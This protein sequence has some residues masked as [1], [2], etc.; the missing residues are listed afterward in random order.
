M[1][2]IVL[3]KHEFLPGFASLFA[4]LIST[5]GVEAVAGI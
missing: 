2:K 3:N 1:I 5:N 4:W